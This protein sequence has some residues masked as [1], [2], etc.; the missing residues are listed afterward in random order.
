MVEVIW[1]E[2]LTTNEHLCDY[3]TDLKDTGLDDKRAARIWSAAYTCYRV[4]SFRVL[5]GLQFTSVEPS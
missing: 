3:S 4:A 5:S 1:E 2:G